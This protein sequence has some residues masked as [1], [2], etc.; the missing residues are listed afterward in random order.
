MQHF[1]PTRSLSTGVMAVALDLFVGLIVTMPVTHVRPMV[2][3]YVGLIVIGT[4]MLLRERIFPPSRMRVAAAPAQTRSFAAP[5]QMHAAE[6]G[7]APAF[8]LVG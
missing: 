2:V 7:H 4:G 3:F 6:L 5:S 1:K 8:E